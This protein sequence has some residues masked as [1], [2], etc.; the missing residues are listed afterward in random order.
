MSLRIIEKFEGVNNEGLTYE[1][2]VIND[3]RRYIK[4]L[5]EWHENDGQTDLVNLVMWIEGMY[6]VRLFME[7][8][9]GLR[10]YHNKYLDQ[11]T[12]A[13]L[14]EKLKHEIVDVV[15]KYD[16]KKNLHS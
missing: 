16:C 2:C 8:M 9:Q 5:E 6:E 15:T 1:Q 4:A 12:N 13:E 7:I 3:V 14:V 10:F 11:M